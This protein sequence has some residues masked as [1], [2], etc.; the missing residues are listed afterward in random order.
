M[1]VGCRVPDRQ[2]QT[3]LRVFSLRSIQLE[4]DFHDGPSVYMRLLVPRVNFAL[5]TYCV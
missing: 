2:S 4:C 5:K 3:L 1:G